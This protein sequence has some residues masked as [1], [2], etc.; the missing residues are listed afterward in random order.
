LV[1]FEELGGDVSKISLVRRSVKSVCAESYENH[2]TIANFSVEGHGESNILQQ[3]NVHLRCAAG[4]SISTIEF[5]S[6]GTPSGTCGSFQKGTCHAPNSLDV[7]EKALPQLRTCKYGFHL[8]KL[9]Y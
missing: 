9:L 6:F 7:V 4:Q 1:V 3:S 2:P 8:L 5:A